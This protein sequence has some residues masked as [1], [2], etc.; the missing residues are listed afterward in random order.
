MFLELSSAVENL[1]D[2][3]TVFIGYPIWWADIPTPLYT[4]FEQADFSGKR[5]IPFSTHGGSR[6]SSTIATI[7][8]LAPEAEVETEDVLT[9]SRDEIADSENQVI[10]WLNDLEL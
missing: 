8:E 1:N 3:D 6:F 4:F 2:Y 9:I 10:D 7:S 5:I